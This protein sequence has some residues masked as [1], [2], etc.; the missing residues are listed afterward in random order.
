MTLV[1]GRG[2]RTQTGIGRGATSVG[3]AAAELA[4]RVFGNDLARQKVMIIGAGQM[5]EA[6]VRHLAKRGAGS[7]LISQAAGL[8]AKLEL[9]KE[10]PCGPFLHPAQIRPRKR[11]PI[12]P[13]SLLSAA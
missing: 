9:E 12:L 5:G 13:A 11:L 8:M 7:I 1:Q 3:S 4:E 10:V 6:C 2:I